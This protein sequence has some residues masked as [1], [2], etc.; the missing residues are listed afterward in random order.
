MSALFG[1]LAFLAFVAFIIGLIKPSLVVFWGKR[2]TRGMAALYLVAALVFV[3]IA[4]ASSPKTSNVTGSKAPGTSAGGS[5]IEK[6]SSQAQATTTT[7]DKTLES[8]FYTVGI[9]IPAGTYDF[10]ALSGGGNVIT[11]DG[12]INEI[13]GTADKGSLYTETFKNAELR[14]GQV[15]SVSGVSIRITSNNASAA[16][17]KKREQTITK[18]EEFGAGNYVAGKDYAAG[19]YDLKALSGGGN[20]MTE[21]GSLNAIMGTESEDMY[22]KTYHNVEFKEGD[23]LTISGNVK[24]SL[25]PSK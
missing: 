15:L 25:T 3:I 23:K 1:I 20:V 5:T 8:G 12:S 16:P 9:D 11:D 19:T 14:D 22:I 10:K 4:A 18:V 6:A 13:M 17:L 2:K 21:D 24:I 7:V